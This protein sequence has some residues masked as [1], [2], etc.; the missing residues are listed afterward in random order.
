MI[1]SSAWEI[2]Q[3]LREILMLWSVGGLRLS[4]C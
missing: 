4:V 2:Q 3:G 1:D